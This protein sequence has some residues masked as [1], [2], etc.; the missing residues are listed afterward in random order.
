MM[1]KL[2]IA[3]GQFDS[4]ANAYSTSANASTRQVTYTAQ[5]DICL[6]LIT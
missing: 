6:F 1:D 5:M 4:T 2:Q 3:E